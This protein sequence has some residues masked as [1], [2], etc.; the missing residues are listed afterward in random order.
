M[1]NS[2]AGRT[3]NSHITTTTSAVADKGTLHNGFPGF[4]DAFHALEALE[5]SFPEFQ[6]TTPGLLL[7]FL[8]TMMVQQA[9]VGL[10]AM[11]QHTRIALPLW[12]LPIHRSHIPS[13]MVQPQ[14]RGGLPTPALQQQQK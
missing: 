14:M 13:R 4:I 3:S 5:A 12:R 6:D 9:M 10:T 1:F 8:L 7:T 2:D 11:T